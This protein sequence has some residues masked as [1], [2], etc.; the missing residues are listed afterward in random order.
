M[1]HAFFLLALIVS[2]SACKKEDNAEQPYNAYLFLKS[3]KGDV[4]PFH[5]GS[6]TK[7]ITCVSS[8]Q[9]EVDYA[10]AGKYFW[11]NEDYSYGG[12]KQDGWIKSEIVGVL[13]ETED[14]YS[15]W[16]VLSVTPSEEPIKSP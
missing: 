14:R 8:A 10:S 1:K 4:V 11:T 9:Y 13:C 2:L 16:K 15:D 7:L 5:L 3:P 6:F 12:V